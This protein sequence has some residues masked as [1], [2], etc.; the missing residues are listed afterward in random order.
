MVIGRAAPWLA[1]L[2]LLAIP[3]AADAHALLLRATPAPDAITAVAPAQIQLAF[4]EDVAPVG[5]GVQVIGPDGHHYER[6]ATRVDGRIV[7]QAVDAGLPR[8][9]SI[10]LWHAISADGHRVAGDFTFS[11]GARSKPADAAVAATARSG[12]A[13]A[14]V[15]MDAVRALR[16]LGVIVLV[17]L[18]LGLGVVWMPTIRGGRKRDAGAADAADRAFRRPAARLAWI[19]APTLAAVA[20]LGLPVEAWSNRVAL[21]DELSLRQGRVA[22]AQAVLALIAWPLL[23]RAARGPAPRAI[24]AGIAVVAALALTP[25]LSGHA[26]AEAAILPIL[27]DWAHVVAAGAWGG[28]LLLLAIAAPPTLRSVDG[29]ARAAL[30]TGVTRRFTRIA[31][32]ALAV[33]VAT[34]ALAGI[35]LAGS[36]RA[37]P[38]SDWGRVLIAKVLIV[39][40]AVAVAGLSRRGGRSFTRGVQLE[41]V[42]IVVVIALTGVLTGL[43]PAPPDARAAAP[44]AFRLDQ[45][46]GGDTAEVVIDPAQAL[47]DAEVHVIVVRPPGAPASG[48][49]DASM[50]L[51]GPGGAELAVPLLPVTDGHWSSTVRIPYPGRW[52]VIVRLRIGEFDEQV[53]TGVLTAQ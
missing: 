1:L 24:V 51:A 53:L 3:A 15:A 42:L 8:G 35:Q 28:G 26:G 37:I 31:L 25:G 22:L 29:D 52:K 50:T 39:A 4:S 20:L 14:P 36:V 40:V 21:A 46:V 5:T 23:V 45:R 19:T 27:A 6:G 44:A 10:V 12:T 17:G 11:V 16:F 9:T 49:R 48:V 30:L 18:A 34:G 33:L 2:G 38:E 43:A 47:R 32:V 41:A 13:R 7:R